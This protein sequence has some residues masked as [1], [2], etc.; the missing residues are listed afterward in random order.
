VLIPRCPDYQIS[1]SSLIL[2][3][4]L[5]SGKLCFALPFNFGNSGVSGKPDLGLLGWKSGDFGN[6]GN[7]FLPL[8]LWLN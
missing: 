2:S 1:R 4:V 5:I 6:S 7:L 8:P 3:S